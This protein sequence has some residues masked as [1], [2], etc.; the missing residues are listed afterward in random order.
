MDGI[1]TIKHTLS[2][3]MLVAKIGGPAYRIG[4]GI[5][6]GAAFLRLS[7]SV[8]ENYH[9]N[10]WSD[11]RIFGKETCESIF[12]DITN[13]EDEVAMTNVQCLISAR[14]I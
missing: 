1:H 2:L 9:P 10:K 8:A 3:P 4:I 5:G 13:V 6:R 12:K 11:R 14:L 7:S